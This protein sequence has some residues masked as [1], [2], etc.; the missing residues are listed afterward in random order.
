MIFSSI[1]D[2]V[3]LSY[4]SAQI[5]QEEQPVSKGISAEK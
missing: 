2:D 3:Y 5:N 4:L 1:L